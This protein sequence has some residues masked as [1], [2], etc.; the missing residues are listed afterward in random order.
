MNISLRAHE[1]IYINGAVVTVDRK[2]NIELLNDATFLLENHVLQ[3]CDATTPLRQIYFATQVMLMDPASADMAK[4]LSRDLITGAKGAFVSEEILKGLETVDA[5]VSR[6]RPFDA[7]KALRQLYPL[8]REIMFP[9][10]GPE[11][12]QVA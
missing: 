9:S 5:L 6:S 4:Q 10:V 12:K 11:I 7:M 1:K 2:V 3:A 8:E